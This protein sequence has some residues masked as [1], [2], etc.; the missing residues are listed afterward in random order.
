MTEIERLR[1]AL[2]WLLRRHVIFA[3]AHGWSHERIDGESFVIDA[4]AALSAT[5][6]QDDDEGLQPML[7]LIEKMKREFVARRVASGA[8]VD[9]AERA[10]TEMLA[11]EAARA[12]QIKRM[13][14]SEAEDDGG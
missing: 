4:R 9:Q 6:P 7:R 10:W 14:E 12:E 2:E 8:T 3:R 11:K 13:L 5:R 1:N